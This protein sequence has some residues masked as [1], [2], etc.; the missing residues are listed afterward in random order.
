[1][2]EEIRMSLPIMLSN[3][4]HYYVYWA[5]RTA[6]DHCEDHRVYLP[7]GSWIGKEDID[8]IISGVRSALTTQ[9]AM[10][11]IVTEMRK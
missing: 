4:E 10:H 11:R 1:M 9:Q 7:D 6:L 2:R 3:A 5:I 8:R